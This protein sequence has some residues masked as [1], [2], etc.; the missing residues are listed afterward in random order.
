MG[1][2]RHIMGGIMGGGGTGTILRDWMNRLMLRVG[3]FA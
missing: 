3:G 2:R 1:G